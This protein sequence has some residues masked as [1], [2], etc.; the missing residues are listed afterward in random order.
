MGKIKKKAS[1]P[2][3]RRI[4]NTVRYRCDEENCSKRCKTKGHLKTHKANTHNIGVV[5]H[6]C[7]EE[8]CSKRCK[9]KGHLKTHKANTHNISAVWHY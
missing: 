8:N 9:T 1:N 6:Y 2:W 4:I 3:R 7:D 5:W